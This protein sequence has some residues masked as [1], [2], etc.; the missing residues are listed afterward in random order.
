MKLFA[1]S[2][3][4]VVVALLGG[5]ESFSPSVASRGSKQQQ[6]QQQRRSS[7]SSL[8]MSVDRRSFA[9]SLISGGAAAAAAAVG[10]AVGSPAPAFALGFGDNDYVPRYEDVRQLLGLGLSLDSLV[11]KVS[12][13]DKFGAASEGLRAWGKDPDFY[14]GYARNYISKS[15]KTN[16]DADVRVGYIRQASTQISA[17]LPLLEGGDDPKT[18]SA[19]AVKKVKNAQRLIAKFLAESG[20][21]DEKLSAFV[22]A[23]P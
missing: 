3:L 13:P 16:A 19:E 21:E 6:Q 17:V 12:D 11:G 8:S 20:A 9:S 2:A 23:H 10:A 7:P 5:V 4:L 22:K 1:T 18:A 15:V 14:T